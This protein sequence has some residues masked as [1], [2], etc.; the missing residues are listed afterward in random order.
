M[1][2]RRSPTQ[3]LRSFGLGLR[4]VIKYKSISDEIRRICR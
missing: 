4:I 3:N 2:K 1:E